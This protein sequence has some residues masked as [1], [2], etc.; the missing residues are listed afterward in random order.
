MIKTI[1]KKLKS[2]KPVERA[3]DQPTNSESV[4][5]VYSVITKMDSTL[6][7]DSK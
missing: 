7:G 5:Y 4:V 2:V 6:L 3:A 1:Q